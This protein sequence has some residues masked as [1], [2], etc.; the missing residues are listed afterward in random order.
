[1]ISATE[2]LQSLQQRAQRR[3]VLAL[4]AVIVPAAY[5]A[6]WVA[7][8]NDGRGTIPAVLGLIAL[9]VWAWPRVLS[10]RIPTMQRATRRLDD[11][12]PELEDSSALLLQPA[13]SLGPMA[14]LQRAEVDRAF[15][16]LANSHA[17]GSALPPL[18]YAPIGT[19]WALTL[20]ATVLLL[21]T[22]ASPQTSDSSIRST[23]FDSLLREASVSLRP[24]AYLQL[25]KRNVAQLNFKT[26]EGAQ[27]S[28]F[29]RIALRADRVALHFHDGEV[30]ALRKLG[31]GRW[32]SPT[33]SARSTV[34]TIHADEAALPNAVFEIQTAADTAPTLEVS[35]PAESLRLLDDADTAPTQRIEFVA[36]DDHQVV[37]AR[38][39]VTLARG[40]G[41]QVQFREQAV[42]LEPV[43]SADGRSLEARVDLDLLAL[44]MQRGDELYLFAEV[45]DNKPEPNVGVSGTYILRWPDDEIASSDPV[46]TIAMDELPEFFRSQ[47]QIIIDTEALISERDRLHESIFN[48][49]AQTLAT[50]QKLLRLRYGQYLGEEIDSG[51]GAAAESQ[52]AAMIASRAESDAHEDHDH[53]REQRD[54]RGFRKFGDEHDEYDSHDAVEQFHAGHDHAGHDGARGGVADMAF[55]DRQAAMD[56]YTHFH[57]TAEQAT[58]FEPETRSLLQ[59]A[60][61]QMWDAELHL[62]LF[63]P[64]AA[65]P[66]EYAALDFIKRVQQSSRIYLRRA[67]FRPT[68]VDESRRLTGELTDI[69]TTDTIGDV[70]QGEFTQL[71]RLFEQ[72]AGGQSSGA[73]L[74][75]LLDRATDLVRTRSE[76]DPAWLGLLAQLQRVQSD[77]DCRECQTALRAALWQRLAPARA[78]P[79]P[80]AAPEHPLTRAYEQLLQ[81]PESS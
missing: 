75:P 2:Q 45:T 60:L 49:R 16:S 55:G 52:I 38:A 28:W 68:P 43:I 64:Q 25:P 71:R 19:A 59:Q 40:S 31:A 70:T 78:A 33:W 27:V 41:E 15:G 3:A 10:A 4:A 39:R 46:V 57:D 1:M 6:T 80:S 36:R 44:G 29:M 58:L 42:E 12:F 79:A 66:Y 11:A 37:A 8:S 65:L 18:P 73:T 67:G 14:T 35:A 47:R 81:T 20:A 63:D 72:L 32:E 56:L 50:D 61:A 77:T 23:T 54:F 34:Y 30:L 24:P 74:R 13:D 22:M 9:I 76:G 21:T 17:L 26:V 5:A 51:I 69:Q 48:Q 53:K 7:R 62:R